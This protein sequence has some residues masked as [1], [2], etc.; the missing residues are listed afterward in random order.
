M[1]E[2]YH[3][4]SEAGYTYSYNKGK[5]IDATRRPRKYCSKECRKKGYYSYSKIPNF[6]QFGNPVELT[7]NYKNKTQAL[8][9]KA[10][11]GCELSILELR[12]R[13]GLKIIK[14]KQQ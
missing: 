12:L 10:R 6:I 5:K 3:C 2:C 9:A 11:A 8:F 7:Q 1:S 4:G 14:S 13:Y